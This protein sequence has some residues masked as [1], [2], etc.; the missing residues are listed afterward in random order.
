MVVTSRSSS[1]S[2]RFC[3]SS[4]SSL[5]PSSSSPLFTKRSKVKIDTAIEYVRDGGNGGVFIGERGSIDNQGPVSD[6]GSESGELELGSSYPQDMD[7]E[8]PMSVMEISLEADTNPETDVLPTPTIPEEISVVSLRIQSYGE[9]LHILPQLLA[10][11]ELEFNKAFLGMCLCLQVKITA[12]EIQGWKDLSIVAFEVA[13]WEH[14]GKDYCSPTDRRLSLDWDTGKTHHYYQCHV[15]SDGSYTFK[16]FD[17]DFF[18]SLEPVGTYLQKVLGDD[19]VLTVV[20]E[21]LQKNS[22]TCSIDPYSA[23]KRIAKNG[24]K[25]G[26]RRYQLFARM[27]FMHVHTLPSSDNYMVRFSLILSKTKKLEVDM[28][29]ITFEIIDDIHCHVLC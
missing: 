28:T 12:E 7:A 24:I 15:A 16:C 4:S 20:F 23:Y 26:L 22:S 13:V 18:L 2:R 3:S 10:L 5:E 1:S 11:S 17:R 9:S 25:I 21:D 8:K 14:L 27:H 6:P 29:G 19:N